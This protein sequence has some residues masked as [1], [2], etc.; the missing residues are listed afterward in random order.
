MEVIGVLLAAGQ[1]RR[2]DAT[3]RRLKLIETCSAG[4]AAGEPL[5]LAAAQALR[6][7][8]GTVVAV[9]RSDRDPK[10]RR[11]HELLAA[12]GC[13]LVA[14]PADGA[15]GMGASI[16]CAV[17]S[18]P[19]AG[20]WII[21]L[22]DMPAIRPATIVAVRAAIAQGAACAA[23]YFQGRRG[24]PVGFGAVCGPELAALHGDAGARAVLERHR[25]LRID[26][27]D[28]GI[29]QDVDLPADL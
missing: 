4:P 24:H 23:P 9:V 3:L 28:P 6:A 2:F 13:T 19:E 21:A 11:L 8:L 16:A 7:A 17:A 14:Y 27:D 20:G 22:A 26:V 15:G 12:A 25:P 5:A 1:G 18:R 29:L 10:Q